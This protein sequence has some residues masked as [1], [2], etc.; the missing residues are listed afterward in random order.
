M[1]CL[2]LRFS[3]FGSASVTISLTTYQEL[4]CLNVISVRALPNSELLALLHLNIFDRFFAAFQFFSSLCVNCLEFVQND[5]MFFQME[6]SLF[7]S[8]FFLW[9]T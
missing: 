9:L 6:S 8:F 4:S 2:T 7:T 5:I 1:K 3:A